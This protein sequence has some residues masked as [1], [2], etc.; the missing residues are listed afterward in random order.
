MHR[1]RKTFLRVAALY[2]AFTLTAAIHTVAV[3]RPHRG[4]LI[5]QTVIKEVTPAEI[6]AATQQSG[7]YPLTG[8]A[9]CGAKI[10]EIFYQTI[11]V[12]GEPADSSGVLIIPTGVDCSGPF[13]L[14]AAGHG[15][16]TKKTDSVVNVGAGDAW[17][18]FFVAQGYA[19]V[20]S[21]YLGLGQSTYPFHP[22]LHADSEASAMIDSLRAARQAGRGLQVRYN[23]QV[24]LIG[25]SQGGHVAMATQR[26][27]EKRY[28]QEFKL[29]A[30]APM[31]GPYAAS[32][33]FIDGWSGYTNGRLNLLAAPLLGLAVVSYQKI[34][35]DL[36]E[37]P[38]DLFVEPYAS[39]V[40]PAFPGTLQ[41]Y[42]LVSTG[43]FPTGDR[44]DAIRQPSFTTQFIS[45]P[46]HPFRR[47]LVRND[48]LDWKPKTP[49]LLCGAAQDSIVSFDNAYRAQAAFAARGV[50]V[51][52]V[53]VG[54]Q[55]PPGLEGHSGAPWCYAAAREQLFEPARALARH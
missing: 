38:I 5:H 54:N 37:A 15:T 14:M 49:L 51:P 40:E 32:Q 34:Y 52:V 19:V 44:V 2:A 46:R 20:A 11:G 39:R 9:R 26:E 41:I 42:E 1:S 50:D 33:T 24:M 12:Q 53:D 31:A 48:L 25:Y 10:I 13:P 55:L 29:V 47:A 4:Q 35:G 16:S 8:P 30:T 36:Y 22:F 28:L 45:N 6:D 21:D 17:I 23:G 27:I 7:L 3:A 18:S 43:L